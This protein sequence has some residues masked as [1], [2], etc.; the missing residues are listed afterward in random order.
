MSTPYPSR[1]SLRSPAQPASGE[2]SPTRP[3]SGTS[4]LAGPPPH[5]PTPT[6]QISPAHAIWLVARREITSQIRTKSFIIST[7]ILVVAVFAL[8]VFGGI[9]AD[10]GASSASVAVVSETAT[11]IPDNPLINISLMDSPEE[12]T[13]LVKE[14]EVDAAILPS[15][16]LTHDPLGYYIVAD[17]EVPQTVTFMTMVSP[18]VE[19]LT[20]QSESDGLQY[21]IAIVFG[22]LFMMS[23]MTFGSTIAQSTVVEK[24][25]RTV[26]L[27]VSAVSTRVLLAGKILGNSILAIGQT[28]AIIVAGVLGLLVTGQSAIL[29]LISAPALWFVVYFVFGFTLFAAIFA[30][31]ASLVSRIEDT[32]AVLSPIMMLAMLPYFLVLLFAHKPTVMLVASYI[33]FTSVVAMPVRMAIGPVAWWAPVLSLLILI[34]TSV[35]VTIIAARIYQAS[36]LRMG[37]R[38]KLREAWAG[39]RS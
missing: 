2:S 18:R 5:T 32:G 27:L 16:D 21:L 12:A 11:V 1:R 20:E 28:V 24:Q 10:R 29:S 17:E 15:D 37:S 23:V 7:A 30:A 3:P 13:A 9:M 19:L 4:S 33:P 35:L 36:V 6:P 31:S 14:G 25:T 22:A 8:T 39:D 38:L 26:E 34:A